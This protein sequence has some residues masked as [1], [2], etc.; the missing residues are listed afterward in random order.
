MS[1][2]PIPIDRARRAG[3]ADRHVAGETTD[4]YR[5]TVLAVTSIGALLASLTA[6][7]LIIAL[8][9]ILRDLQ[10]T[11]FALLWIV[12]GYTLVATVL[13]LNAGTIADQIGR[14]R[15]YTLGFGVFTVASVLCALAP[16]DLLLIGG[17]ILQGVGGA[18]LMANSAA[19]VTDAFPRGE[20][21]RALGINAMVIG[22]G[23]ILGPILGGWLTGFG[24]RTVF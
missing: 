16:T 3:S 12:I 14:A 1:E 7:T 2:P 10:T 21:G 17:R 5:W 4:S 23:Q 8:P 18:L 13:V 24:W 11:L 19:L 22:A 20:L 15:S 6:G 9:D